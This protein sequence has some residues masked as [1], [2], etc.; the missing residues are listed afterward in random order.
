MRQRFADSGGVN[1]IVHPECCKEVVDKADH[2]GSTEQIIKTIEAAEPGSNWAV[3]TE[4]HLVNRV[5]QA[6][7]ERD[8]TVAMLSE[9]Q[10]L[11]TTMYRIEPTNLLWV[12][13]NLAEGNVVNQITV[14]PDA[15][16]QAILALDRMLANVAAPQPAS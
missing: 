4:V 12:L 3:G 10:C 5:A 16:K 2:S 6:A 15:Q 7:A 13:D 8:V 9:C 14:H 1:V 11:C